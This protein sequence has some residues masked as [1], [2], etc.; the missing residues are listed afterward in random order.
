MNTKSMVAELARLRRQLL[1]A[2]QE[3]EILK[4]P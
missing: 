1:I 4:E 2:E 3:R